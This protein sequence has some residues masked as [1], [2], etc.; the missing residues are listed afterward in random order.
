MKLLTLVLISIQFSGC[1]TTPQHIGSRCNKDSKVWVFDGCSDKQVFQHYKPRPGLS[2]Q[3]PQESYENSQRNAEI[4][5]IQMEQIRI[6]N[7][8]IK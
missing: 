6:E 5:N 4:Y 1:A 3:I 8:L 2:T 7:D